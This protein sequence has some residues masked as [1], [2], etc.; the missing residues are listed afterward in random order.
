M[1]YERNFKQCSY[2]DRHS[3]AKYLLIII[4]KGIY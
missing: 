1:N 4:S 2:F 3:S